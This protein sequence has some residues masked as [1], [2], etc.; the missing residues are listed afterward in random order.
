MEHKENSEKMIMHTENL[1]ASILNEGAFAAA[2]LALKE[3]KPSKAELVR[4]VE[5][6]TGIKPA[7]KATVKELYRYIESHGASERRHEAR[8]EIS[9]RMMPI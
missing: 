3:A 6:L 5:D 9:R 4:I 1:K 8:A 7:S 2:V